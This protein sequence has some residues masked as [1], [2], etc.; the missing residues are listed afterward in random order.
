MV[1][2]GELFKYIQGQ[3]HKIKGQGKLCKL[4]KTY[5]NYMS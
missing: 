5:F 3:G 1:S 2:I 4:K